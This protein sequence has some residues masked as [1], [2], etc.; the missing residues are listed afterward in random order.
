MQ[1]AIYQH[2]A[3]LVLAHGS[4]AHAAGELPA[5]TSRGTIGLSASM[6]EMAVACGDM[7]A[8]QAEAQQKQ[9][10]AAASKSLNVSESE[11]ERI[12]AQSVSDFKQKW[13]KATP[14]QKKQSCEQ[15]KAMSQLQNDPAFKALG[16]K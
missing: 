4:A 16:K 15:V 3:A 10:R 6:N 14:A 5:Q 13:S 2:T 9:Q 11:Y 8:A 7:T 12:Y 1:P